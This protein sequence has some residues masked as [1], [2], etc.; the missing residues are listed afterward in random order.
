MIKGFLE[1]RSP[2]WTVFDPHNLIQFIQLFTLPG[3]RGERSEVRDMEGKADKRFII[4]HLIEYWIL[5]LW[6]LPCNP[7]FY[8]PTSPLARR[9]YDNNEIS[10]IL[11]SLRSLRLVVAERMRQGAEDIETQPR[12]WSPSLCHHSHAPRGRVLRGAW[13]EP[14]HVAQG[15]WMGGETSGTGWVMTGGSWGGLVIMVDLGLS[16]NVL[17]YLPA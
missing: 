1:V 17:S 11:S 3:P 14:S 13:S 15:R 10:S 16:L 7:I 2:S 12:K 4:P 8:S 5:Y 6:S 9:Q